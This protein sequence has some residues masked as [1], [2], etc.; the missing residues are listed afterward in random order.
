MEPN[1]RRNPTLDEVI[2]NGL[3][4]NGGL[5]IGQN[6]FMKL[7]LDFLGF[8]TFALGATWNN[9]GRPGTHCVVT[10]KNDFTDTAADNEMYLIDV[11]CGLPSW[12]PI[13]LH[14]LPFSRVSGGYPFEIRRTPEG[15]YQRVHLKGNFV[16]GD[17]VSHI[18]EKL[19]KN[20][21]QQILKPHCCNIAFT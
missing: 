19:T 5:C 7:V 20:P 3:S 12:E 11:G 4:G 6:Y 16:K 8:T 10:V 9:A 14:Q 17:F 1:E 13:P 21:N 18:L 2:S 15:L